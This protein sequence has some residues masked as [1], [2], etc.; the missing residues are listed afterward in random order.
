[1]AVVFG[2]KTTDDGWLRVTCIQ[3]QMDSHENGYSVDAK[4]IPDYPTM[5]R[6][7]SPVQMYHPET[8]QWRF[9]ETDVPLTKEQILE[10]LVEA[11]RELTA[12]LKERK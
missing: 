3:Y 7:K 12:V 10:E 9:D 4:D 8:K 2:D 11:V 5:P 1:M 6:G